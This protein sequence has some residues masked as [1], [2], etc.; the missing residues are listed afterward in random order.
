MRRPPLAKG[1][2]SPSVEELS[3]SNPGSPLVSNGEKSHLAI[4]A[5]DGIGSL[6][7]CVSGIEGPNMFIHP[8]QISKMFRSR[9]TTFSHSFSDP[10]TD[11]DRDLNGLLSSDSDSAGEVEMNEEASPTFRTP[12]VASF[13]ASASLVSHAILP[14]KSSTLI[15]ECRD[16]GSHRIEIS[17][18]PM[19]FS[20]PPRSL[21]SRVDEHAI[22]LGTTKT[23]SGEETPKMESRK[24]NLDSPTKPK[25]ERP[26]PNIRSDIP[27][28]EMKSSKESFL[29]QV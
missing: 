24:Q 5:A 23:D 4:T 28:M 20:T 25:V 13:K 14:K 2:G 17:T 15:I 19:S 10:D 22:S 9:Q 7:R 26:Q 21:S 11:S 18:P 6:A 8:R 27:N 29:L 16:E 1:L 3:E 12:K